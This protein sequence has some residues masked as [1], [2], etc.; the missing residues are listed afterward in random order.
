MKS[1]AQARTRTRVHEH[2]FASRDAPLAACRHARARR[3]PRADRRR[4][5]RSGVADRRG[6]LSA[7]RRREARG[8][9]DARRHQVPGA[10]LRRRGRGA[11]RLLRG[12]ARARSSGAGAPCASSASARSTTLTVHREWSPSLG[13]TLAERI[14]EEGPLYVA[15][16]VDRSSRRPRPGERRAASASCTASLKPSKPVRARTAST[17][18]ASSE[19]DQLRHREGAG[20]PRRILAPVPARN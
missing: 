17:A 5:V 15:D 11:E 14:A 4:K 9:R 8:A 18:R 13:R 2:Q 19:G 7:S 20:E 1:G 12:R 3:R 6:R 16:A 10:E